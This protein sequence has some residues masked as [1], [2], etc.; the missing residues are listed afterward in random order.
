MIE[1][2]VDIMELTKKNVNR[3]VAVGKMMKMILKFLGASMD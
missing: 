3:E 2:N 1:K